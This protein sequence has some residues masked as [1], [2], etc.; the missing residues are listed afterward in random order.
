MENKEFLT[1]L[2][3]TYD[4]YK[5]KIHDSYAWFCKHIY[6]PNFL[7]MF[8]GSMRITKENENALKTGYFKYNDKALPALTRWF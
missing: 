3:N 2:Q 4:T 6:V 1:K 5:P 7:G 8:S